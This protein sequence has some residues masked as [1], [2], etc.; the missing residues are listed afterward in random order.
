MIYSP[1]NQIKHLEARSSEMCGWNPG[2][3]MKEASILITTNASKKAVNNG[4]CK[5]HQNSRTETY[6]E[7][8]IIT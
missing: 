8:E 1:F 3:G 6:D 7:R 5:E 4:H 2:K